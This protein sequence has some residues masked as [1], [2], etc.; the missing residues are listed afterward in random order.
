MQGGA[1]GSQVKPHKLSLT[2]AAE[3]HLSS[4]SMS[5]WSSSTLNPL[6]RGFSSS[7]DGG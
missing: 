6:E 5:L 7:K 4:F 3:M 1:T 2:D